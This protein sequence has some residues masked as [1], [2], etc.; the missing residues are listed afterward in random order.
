MKD[1]V[2]IDIEKY[3]DLKKEIKDLKEINEIISSELEETRS[4][5]EDYMRYLE[6]EAKEKY[7]LI[8]ASVD[9][10]YSIVEEIKYYSINEEKLAD[11]LNEKYFD[12][13]VEIHDTLKKEGNENE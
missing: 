13:F 8:K 1:V 9:A 2:I 11:L 5:L 10:R 4:L 7:E 12:L 3:E 6:K